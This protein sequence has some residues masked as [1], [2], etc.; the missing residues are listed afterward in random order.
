MEQ[1]VDVSRPEDRYG[2]APRRMSRRTATVLAVAA[3]TLAVALIALITFGNPQKVAWQDAAFKV[4]G[5]A[6]VTV[7]FAVTMKPG[8]T[9]VCTVQALNIRF[10]EVGRVDV[11]VGPSKDKVVTSTVTIPTSERAN[12]GTVKACAEKS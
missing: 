9:A 11:V 2:A 7:T 4:Q 8:T 10:S 3:I 12:T 1:R 6:A 5:D